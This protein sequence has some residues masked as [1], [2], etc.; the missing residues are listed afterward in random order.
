MKNF[1]QMSHINSNG[2]EPYSELCKF[3]FIIGCACN[4]VVT[5]VSR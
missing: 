1:S 3:Y 5:C 4:K 2:L